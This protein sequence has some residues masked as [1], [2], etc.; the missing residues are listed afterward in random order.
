MQKSYQLVLLDNEK[1]AAFTENEISGSNL[2]LRGAIN[3]VQVNHSDFD[4][5]RNWLLTPDF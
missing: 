4:S 3:F 2:Q 5:Y 1:I